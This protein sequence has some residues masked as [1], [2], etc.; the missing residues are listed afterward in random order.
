M[1]VKSGT[2][3]KIAKVPLCNSKGSPCLKSSL[4]PLL[5]EG[6]HIRRTKDIQ[7]GSCVGYQLKR[8]AKQSKNLVLSVRRTSISDADIMK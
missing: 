7:K 1:G 8:A 2:A 4:Q 5:A 3:R 6:L